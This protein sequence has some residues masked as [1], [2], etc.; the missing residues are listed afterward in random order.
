MLCFEISQKQICLI[1]AKL[2]LVWSFQ[3][4]KKNWQ[5]DKT[6]TQF[7]EEGRNEKKGMKRKT[8]RLWF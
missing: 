7:R 2:L 4:G 5:K 3:K 1:W 8:Q 6:D